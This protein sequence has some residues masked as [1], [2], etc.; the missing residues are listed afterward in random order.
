M[1]TYD[2]VLPAVV[3]ILRA[4]PELGA[5]APIVINRDLNGRVR[6]VVDARLGTREEINEA[7]GKSVSEIFDRIGV[8]AHHVDRALIVEDNFED[9]LN[10]GYAY[11][12]CLDIRVVERLATEG[13]WSSISPV[14]NG[15]TRVTFFSIKGGVGRSTAMASIAWSLAKSGK[16][17]LVVDLD[18]ES[19]GLSSS[20]L[21]TEYRPR[22]GVTDWLVEDLVGNGGQ[23]FKDIVATSPLSHDGDIFVV[24]AYGAA[25]GEYV[26]KL[27]RAWMPVLKNGLRE[28]WSERL[29]RLLDALEE[30]LVPDII[31]IDS[32]A[33]I[34]EVASACVTDLG[35]ALVLLFAVD[36]EQTWAGYKVLFNHWRSTGVARDIRERLQVVG[37][38][39][40]EDGSVE[41]LA[42]LRESSWDLFNLN[43]YDEVAPGKLPDEAD[44]SFGEADESAPHYPWPIRWQRGFSSL[45]SLHGRLE[46]VD[47]ELVNMSFGRLIQEISLI[48]PKGGGD[49]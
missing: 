38:V 35:A 4:N 26:S 28:A 30:R 20:L 40:P 32:R 17:V 46:G 43:L 44:W 19:P 9:V 49:A 5:L 10:K 2:E 48:I 1:T 16:R 8:Y 29:G 33:G 18:L 24:P 45:R 15:A 23:V 31:L 47:E 22:F 6:L 34:D 14:S 39:I 13:S 11:D 27:G 7:L 42:L 25:P 37:A 36:G 12:G 41:Y 21:P 3:E